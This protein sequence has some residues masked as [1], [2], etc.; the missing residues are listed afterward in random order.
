MLRYWVLKIEAVN[1]CLELQ[2]C[3]VRMLS[4]ALFLHPVLEPHANAM[5]TYS[6]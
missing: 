6:L 5:S 2:N 1:L 3:M 4:Q